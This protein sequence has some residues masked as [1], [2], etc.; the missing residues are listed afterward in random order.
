MNRAK[1][2]ASQDT[3]Q[4]TYKWGEFLSA[5]HC[6]TILCGITGTHTDTKPFFLHNFGPACLYLSSH[7][8]CTGKVT[9]QN[10]GK[11]FETLLGMLRPEESV[12][13]DDIK[14][15]KEQIFGPNVFWV[16]ET[17]ATDDI[18]DGGIV[19]CRQLL[20]FT[21]CCD[22]GPAEADAQGQSWLDC[23]CNRTIAS[24]QSCCNC[25]ASPQ[26]TA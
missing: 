19:V 3:E 13:K 9:E 11:D 22:Q 24:M 25:G 1:Q 26:A 12:N 18:L 21:A 4:G 17:R 10:L 5:T 20:I 15:L 2:L 14:I 8:K 16:T 23:L 7:A 6:R